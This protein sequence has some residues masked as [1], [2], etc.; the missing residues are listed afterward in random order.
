M[1]MQHTALWRPALFA[2]LLSAL[3]ATAHADEFSAVEHQRQTIYHSPQ[4]PG[5]TSWAGAWTMPDRSLMVSFTQA[6]GPVEG[7]PRAPKEVQ[8]QLTWPPAGRPGYDMTGLD[9]RNV[10]LRSTDAGKTWKQVSADAFKSCMNGITGEAQTALADGTIV[11][12]V[13]GYYLPYN[14]ELPKTGYLER[15]TDGSKT[16]GKPEVLLDPKKYSAWPKRLR[17]LRDGRLLAIGGV[18]RVPANSLTRAEYNGLF[19]PL[20]M[21]S[22]DQGKTW[23]GP[24]TVVP[25]E[26][27]AKWGGEEFDVAEL[28]NG[29]LL[30]VFRRADPAKG[31]REARWQGVLRKSGDTWTPGKVEPAP[32]PHSGHPDVLATREGPILHVATS[33]IHWTTDAGQTWQKLDVPGTAYYP[34]AVQAA[35][36]RIFV[37]GHV[38]GDNAYGSVDQSIVMD[39]FRLASHDIAVANRQTLA[40]DNLVCERIPLGAADDYKPCIAR[41]PSGEL[42]LT[43]FHQ[44]KRDG[45]KVMEQTLLFRSK[46]GGRTWSNPQPLDL[47]GR[48]PYLTVLKNGTVFITGHLLAQDV[49][50]KWGYTTGFVHR[51][52][53][54]GR[55]W[56]STRVESEEIKPKASNHTTRNVLELADGSLLLGADYDGGGGPYFIWRSTDGG[57]TWDKSQKCEPRDFKSRYGFF[58]GETWLWQARS[59][60]VWALVRVDSNEMPIKD[61]PIKA[62]N[63]Q[64]DHFTL[65]SSADGGKTF[66]RIRDIGDYGEMYMSLL[67]LQDKRL[68]LTF[69]VRDLKPPLGVRALAGT[70]T[71]D[72]F[73]FDFAH[74]RIMLDTRTPIGKYQGGGFGPTVQLD[75]GTLVTSYSYRGEDDKSHLEVVRWRLPPSR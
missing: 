65:F 33:G 68:L 13:W 3:G 75:D 52:T 73:E 46:D 60:K 42:L 58:G 27:R 20:L 55:T 5:F 11:R 17:V 36:G 38:G 37:F 64:A 71:D 40:T 19:E 32:F 10:H 72:G 12:G 47:L 4:K 34:R 54:G 6:T 14:P 22:S 51:S 39:S 48:E 63:D 30:C 35:D 7:R 53:D 61:R 59:G 66:D 31:G 44:H 23:K 28:P 21:V 26:Y 50:N 67:R 49:R 2:L 43:A 70:E 74:D 1:I 56:Q 9:L 16:W 29:D 69:T 41:L 8:H 24:I 62:G 57:K 15:S 45:N 25:A 18:A